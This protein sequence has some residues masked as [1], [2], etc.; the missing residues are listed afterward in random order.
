MK[1][2]LSGALA[3]ALCNASI[4][5]GAAQAN[6]ADQYPSRPIRVIVPFA[7]GGGLDITTRLIG[8]R[9]IDSATLSAR[10]KR[11]VPLMA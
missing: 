10:T 6:A 5:A 4:C 3:L 9:I 11:T 7:P 1:M 8:Q 2:T